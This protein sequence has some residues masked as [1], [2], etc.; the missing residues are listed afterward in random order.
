MR[1]TAPN[2]ARWVGSMNTP[3]PNSGQFLDDDEIPATLTPI[4]KTMFVEAMPAL[5]ASLEANAAWI[6]ANPD[7]PELPRMVGEHE[8]VIGGKRGN[9]TI[10]S[11]SQWMLQRPL[12]HYASLTGTELERADALLKS[13]GGYDCM[14][15][16]IIW[17]VE[18]RNN[19]L[20]AATP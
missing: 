2:V 1:R 4:L 10:R 15:T 7:T 18:R 20:V 16:E 17:P 14:Q 9:R 3:A 19:L 8:F 6:K 11:Y 5:M 12:A 13:V